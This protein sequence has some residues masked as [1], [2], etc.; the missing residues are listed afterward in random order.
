MKTIRITKEFVFDMAHALHEYNGLCRN[1]HGHTY[2]LQVCLKGAIN[3][4]SSSPTKGMVM[5]FGDLK[6]I[7]KTDIVDRFDHALVLNK[8][9]DP[10]EDIKKFQQEDKYIIVPFQP[11]C[12]NLVAYFAEYI[13]NK[14]PEGIDLHS[15]RLYETP[16]SWGEWFAEDN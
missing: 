2:K 12:E 13:F 9:H 16:T 6:K 1:I 14:L 11:T 3:E 7:V 4:D 10:H 5:D 8:E 15:I